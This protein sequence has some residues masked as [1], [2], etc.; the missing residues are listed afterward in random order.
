M[1]RCLGDLEAI[2]G[3]L[4]VRVRKREERCAPCRTHLVR[5]VRPVPGLR[6]VGI[7]VLV[8]LRFTFLIVY[9]T[10]TVRAGAAPHQAAHGNAQGREN[11]DLTSS[12][13]VKQ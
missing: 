9:I 4:R 12:L 6:I 7:R 5:I 2:Q 10:F 8:S 11:L 3:W 1:Y 13:Q